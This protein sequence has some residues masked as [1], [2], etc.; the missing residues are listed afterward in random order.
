MAASLVELGSAAK[1][2]PVARRAL[3]VFLKVGATGEPG[4]SMRG[5]GSRKEMQANRNKTKEKSFHF[6]SFPL[7]NRGFSMGYGESK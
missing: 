5:P 7:P 2:A 3:R 1:N 6:L 4:R